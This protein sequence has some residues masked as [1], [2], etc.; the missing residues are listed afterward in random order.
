MDE[1]DGNRFVE[2]E[3]LSAVRAESLRRSLRK[4]I[5]KELNK[6]REEILF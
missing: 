2:D 3:S 4:E 1:D 5:E 6:E